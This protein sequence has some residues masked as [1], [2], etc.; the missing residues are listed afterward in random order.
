M[1]S[2]RSV[3]RRAAAARLVCAG[4]AL[5]ALSSSV[6]A[7]PDWE[8]LNDGGGDAGSFGSNAQ[9]V[10]GSGRIT[11]I[12]GVL[13]G[14][15]KAE[16]DDYE[17][18]YLVNI[19]DP[20]SFIM[21]TNEDLGG[22][23]AFTSRIWVFDLHGFGIVAN[24]TTPPELIEETVGGSTVTAFPT[25]GSQPL[26]EPGLYYI[27]ITGRG[28]EPRSGDCDQLIF[29]FNEDFE[30]SGPDGRGSDDPWD[31]WD[32][33]GQF[34]SYTVMV[35]GVDALPR[36]CNDADVAAPFG[37]LNVADVLAFIGAFS[38]GVFPGDFD[39]DGDFDLSD[40]Q[41]YTAAYAEGCETPSS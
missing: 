12:R 14:P 38:E 3:G 17:D 15:A 41:A 21:S 37:V 23:A 7:G 22:F 39:M 29:D 34:G 11:V 16:G 27:A 10:R 19:V 4:I 24:E 2:H 18:V 32:D 1:R 8:E 31:S 35:D 28:N 33:D 40:I 9:V 26:M 25:D 20:Q 36:G 5:C 6:F 30:I 13:G